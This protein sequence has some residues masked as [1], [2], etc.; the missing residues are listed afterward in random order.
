MRLESLAHIIRWTIEVL[1]HL[2]SLRLEVIVHLRLVLPHLIPSASS[3]FSVHLSLIAE[4]VAHGTALV[5]QLLRELLLLRRLEVLLITKLLVLKLEVLLM[6]FG[7]LDSTELIHKLL[8]R[9][10]ITRELI[11]ARLLSEVVQLRLVESNLVH[12]RVEILVCQLD[13]LAI[14]L[15]LWR[16]KHHIILKL[17]ALT[18]ILVL[19]RLTKVK[20][21]TLWYPI[22]HMV[23]RLREI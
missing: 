3:I 4:G 15:E 18:K 20:I 10:P 9:I 12:L 23:V 11:L 8:L 21:L 17:H 1:V 2:L 19:M 5:V 13:I 14:S 16:I 6:P 7:T 22:V